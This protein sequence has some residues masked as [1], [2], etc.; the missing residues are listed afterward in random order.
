[1]ITMLNTNHTKDDQA[2][3]FFGQHWCHTFKYKLF[4][5]ELPMLVQLQ[6]KWSD[7]YHSTTCILCN[8]RLETQTHLWE[9]YFTYQARVVTL[10]KAAKCLFNLII[11]YHLKSSLILSDVMTL[12]YKQWGFLYRCLIPTLLH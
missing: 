6:V 9:C 8:D 10:N 12:F 5:N 3:T 7:L 1:M 2:S 11:K 4:S